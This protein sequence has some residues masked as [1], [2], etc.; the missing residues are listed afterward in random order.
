MLSTATPLRIY[1]DQNKWIELARI[2]HGKET[3]AESQAMLETLQE[4]VREGRWILPLSAVHYL[5]LARI[6]NADRRRR[7][8]AVMY[9]LSGVQTLAAMRRIVEHEI[10]V[11]LARHGFAI[12]VASFALLGRGIGHAF[13]VEFALGMGLPGELREEAIERMERSVL[14]GDAHLDVASPTFHGAEQRERFQR[15][16]Q[17]MKHIR[18]Q[19]PRESWEDALCA[20]SMI[21]ILDPLNC[22]FDRHGLDKSALLSL[23]K[24]KLSRWLASMPIRKVDLHLHRQVLKNPQYRPKVTDL[25][26]WAALATA[27][28]YCDVVVCEKHMAAMLQRD[29]FETRARIGTHLAETLQLAKS[30][31]AVDLYEP[32]EMGF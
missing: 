20:I 26:D 23:D 28:V 9:A 2:F 1:L 22:V 4:E 5:E 3:S 10:E 21:D 8:G 24:P 27:S 30:L 29:H 18:D 13:G 6:S 32:D 11:A 16:L 17:N 19:V 15:H 31:R 25:E 7:L 14:T 12:E